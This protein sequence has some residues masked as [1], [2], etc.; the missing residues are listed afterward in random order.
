MIDKNFIYYPSL[1]A[2]S[3]VSA[4][5]KNTKFEDGTTCRFFSKEYPEEWRHPYFLIT[6]GHHFKKMD[7]RDQIGL[8]DEVLVFGDS[9]GYQIATGALKYSNDLREKIFHWLEANSDV[10]AN[11]DIPPKTVYENKF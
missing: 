9:G 3:M 4:F 8:D 1:S 7:F 10:A 11:L 5:K 6:A 2:G